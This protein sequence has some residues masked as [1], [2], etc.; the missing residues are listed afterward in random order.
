MPSPGLRSQR[1]KNSR[2]R[3]TPGF[4]CAQWR[5][6][7]VEIRVMFE[8]LAPFCDTA[9]PPGGHADRFSRSDKILSTKFV[10]RAARTDWPVQW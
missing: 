10:V 8:T 4:L 5:K 1:R 9:F 2:L 7:L 3:L 6:D